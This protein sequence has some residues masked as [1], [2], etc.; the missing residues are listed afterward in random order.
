MGD[1]VLLR[2]LTKNDLA[3]GHDDSID[4]VFAQSG[5]N[6]LFGSVLARASFP[7]KPVSIALFFTLLGVKKINAC[8]RSG[9]DALT[10]PRWYSAR[11]NV[12]LRHDVTPLRFRT[13]N[14]AM[15][16]AHALSLRTVTRCSRRG[17]VSAR[18]NSWY[19][20]SSLVTRG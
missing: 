14:N 17:T 19:R 13:F 10:F 18:T 11:L 6:S 12:L 9:T 5:M 7:Y 1:L 8:A 3:R 4:R 15:E 2:E 16:R 20:M